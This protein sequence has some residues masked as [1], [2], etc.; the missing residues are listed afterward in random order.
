MR[1][2]KDGPH[3]SFAVCDFCEADASG[4]IGKVRPIG[5][6]GICEGCLE[7]LADLLKG[8]ASESDK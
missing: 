4:N 6:K 2:V 1:Y 8:T 3:Y 7:Q 5:D